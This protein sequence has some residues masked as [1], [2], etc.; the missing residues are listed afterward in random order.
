M[1]KTN[2]IFILA[3][4]CVFSSCNRDVEEENTGGDMSENSV[5]LSETQLQNAEI[6]TGKIESRS[7]SSI[8]NVSGTIDVPPQNMVSI[9]APLGGYLQSTKLLPGMHITKGEVIAIMEDQQYIALQQEYLI[10]SA[11]LNFAEQEYQRQLELNK[12]K[13]VSDKVFQ[14]AD[15]KFK[16][17]KILVKSMSEKLKLIG[18]NPVTLNEDNLSKS[19]SIKSPINGYVTKVNVNIGK[20]V[21]PTDV[22]FELVN[23]ED[24]HIALTVFEKDLNKLFIGQKLKAF[25]NS[26][27]EKKFPGE[28]IFIGKELSEERNTIVH[29]HFDSYDKELIPGMFMNAEIEIK[30]NNDYALPEEAVVYF[31]GKHY[32][33]VQKKKLEY[34]IMEVNVIDTEKGLTLVSFIKNFD[35]QNE[36]FVLKGAYTLLMKMKNTKE[37]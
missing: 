11:N 16:N 9:S 36:I 21:N 37:E 14:E 31:E 3:I 34:E 20:Y 7:I 8:L 27:P 26:N 18:I 1:K 23:P 17:Q 32:V 29:C 15:V 33:F 2:I 25:T 35:V 5:V 30:N 22:L 13:A 6:I 28:I 10:A 19:I 24:I 12:S 4:L